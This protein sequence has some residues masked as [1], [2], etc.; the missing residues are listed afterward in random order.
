M[1]GACQNIG[2]AVP[3]LR[4]STVRPGERRGIPVRLPGTP[5][6]LTPHDGLSDASAR[7]RREHLFVDF[8]ARGKLRRAKIALP[9]RALLNCIPIR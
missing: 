8:P 7:Y 5:P 3:L 2:A 6:E 4:G 9:H 1:E